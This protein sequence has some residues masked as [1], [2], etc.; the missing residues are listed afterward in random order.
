[1]PAIF[2]GYVAALDKASFAQALAKR[3]ELRRVPVWRCRSEEPD[4]RHRRV[5]S[6]R[7][8]RARRSR[9]EQCDELAPF[10]AEHG[11]FLPRPLASPPEPESEGDEC[12]SVSC[13]LS[14]PQRARQVLGAIEGWGG[15]PLIC[16]Y[17]GPG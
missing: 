16:L 2:D 9:A 7:P 8:E 1:R 10:Y 12:R 17:P 3:S 15:L 5:L 6:A 14:L 13:T 4:H 11:E